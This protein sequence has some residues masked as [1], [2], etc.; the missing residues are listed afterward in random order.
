MGRKGVS[1]RKTKSKTAPVSSTNT[2]STVANIARS[3]ESRAPQVVGKGEA[4]SVDKG[5]KKSNKKR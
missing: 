3:A 4:V 5:G 1:K 2:N